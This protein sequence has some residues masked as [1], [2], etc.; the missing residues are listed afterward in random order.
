MSSRVNRRFARR[1]AAVVP[2]GGGSTGSF[3]DAYTIN[4]TGWLTVPIAAAQGAIPTGTGVSIDSLLTQLDVKNQWPDHSM[5]LGVLTALLASTGPKA[6]VSAAAPTGVAFLPT[7]PVFSVQFVITAGAGAGDTYTAALGAYSAAD[8]WL[9]G[10][11]VTEWRK[12]VRPIKVG[13]V[14]HDNLL[15]I[16]DVRSFNDGDHRIN[17]QVLNCRDNA[18]MDSTTYSC[19]FIYSGAVVYSAPVAMKHYTFT[20]WLQGVYLGPGREATVTLNFAKF[21]STYQLPKPLAGIVNTD[22]TADL[23]DTSKFAPTKFGLINP[24]LATGGAA[25]HLG[26]MSTWDMQFLVNQSVSQRAVVLHHAFNG[27]GAFT[28]SRIT[29]TDDAHFRLDDGVEG[30]IF[31]GPD[32]S[33]TPPAYPA[34]LRCPQVF[35]AGEGNYAYRGARNLDTANYR[36]DDEHIPQVSLAAYLV[37]G[38]RCYVDAALAF[39]TA[40]TCRTYATAAYLADR[41]TD[42]SQIRFDRNATPG[43]HGISLSQTGQTDPRAH[44]RTIRNVVYAAQLVPDADAERSYWLGLVNDNLAWFDYYNTLRAAPG[45]QWGDGVLFFEGSVG[46]V[47]SGTTTGVFCQIW[48]NAEIA[49]NIYWASLQGVF[50]LPAGAVTLAKRIV[51]LY[52]AMITHTSDLT[53]V[54]RLGPYYPQV[55]KRLGPVSPPSTIQLPATYA[56]LAALDDPAVW[57]YATL[58]YIVGGNGVHTRL[59][60]RLAAYWSVTDAV[61]ANTLV[62]AYG[63]GAIEVDAITS[64]N[65]YAL[66]IPQT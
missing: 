38:D 33:G 53:E 56:D 45:T 1:K 63:A 9:E 51:G 31:M 64:Q 22:Y 57:P 5:K 34:A 21:Y 36:L 27:I 23:A 10:P 13:P 8:K 50:T 66:T 60:A 7:A 17:V 55:A 30:S 6:I 19:T 61:T 59:G 15:V 4:Q 46:N 12:A 40:T 52:V 35:N 20:P 26:P 39:A 54:A 16:F 41:A 48:G 37:T 62:D 44:A 43:A 25:G 24:L 2:G 14:E 18:N 47:I 29:R 32:T 28:Q 58:G 65:Q 11:N 49:W 3:A 42:G